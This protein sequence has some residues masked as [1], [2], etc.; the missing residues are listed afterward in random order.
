MSVT[1]LASEKKAR[2]NYIYCL[3]LIAFVCIFVIAGRP[4]G[5]AITASALILGVGALIYRCV[6]GIKAKFS[7]PARQR[8]SKHEFAQRDQA[9]AVATAPLPAKQLSKSWLRDSE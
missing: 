9:A 3:D 6:L 1:K 7:A 5:L 4:D 8:K 2:F